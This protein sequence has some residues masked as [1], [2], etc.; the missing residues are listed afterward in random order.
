MEYLDSSS[1]TISSTQIM[2][3]DAKRAYHVGNPLL[4][5]SEIQLR[6][7]CRHSIDA[8]ESWSRRLIDEVL[9]NSYGANYVD[10]V[11]PDGK[12]LVKSDI[13]RRIEDRINANPGRYPRKIDATVM[14]DI[15]YF[16]CRD[17]LYAEHFKPVLEPG[18]S[19]IPEIRRLMEQLISIRNKLSHGTT[20][21][22]HEAEQCLCYTNDFI[23]VYKQHFIVVG[24]ERDYNVPLFIRIKDC[25]GNDVIRNDFDGA[26][27]ICF[28]GRKGN[29]KVQLRSGETYKLWL[30]IDSSFDSALYD[31]NWIISRGYKERIASGDGTEVILSLFNQDVAYEII[32]VIHLK[33]KKD[34]H[35]LQDKDD[36]VFIHLNPILPPIED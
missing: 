24:K 16:L 12:A 8:F 27:D 6:D 4:Y 3:Q 32:I 23:D 20:I 2:L 34:W 35:R 9:T 19:G 11:F 7:I 10:F 5:C 18:F 36:T 13:K 15:E 28:N 29:P 30:E 21:S 1:D 33:T 26:W 22:V 25:L 14:E 17:D 31:V